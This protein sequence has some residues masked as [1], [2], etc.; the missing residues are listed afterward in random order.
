[1]LGIVKMYCFNLKNKTRRI[2]ICL[3][4]SRNLSY[5][6]KR[7]PSLTASFRKPVFILWCH[8]K[9]LFST[10][11]PGLHISKTD[12]WDIP[13]ICDQ[14]SA[15]PWYADE[16]PQPRTESKRWG[17]F[18][19]KIANILLCIVKERLLR[20]YKWQPLGR[21]SIFSKCLEIHGLGKRKSAFG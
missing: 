14:K 2:W 5:G 18:L 19:K 13:E 16:V 8:W 10:P 4:L 1:M 20:K 7:S 15:F 6:F 3:T 9:L 12:C 21:K 11:H 17:S